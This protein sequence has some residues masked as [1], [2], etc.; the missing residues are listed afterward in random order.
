MG[1]PF[2]PLRLI[3]A[4][5]R[6]WL[7]L[8][9]TAAVLAA[10]GGAVAWFKFQKEYK[11][12]AQLMRQEAAS[13]F[14]AS[15]LGEPFKPRE[16]SVTTLVSLMKSPVVMDR[17]S[18]QTQ[19]SPGQIAGGLAIT[20]ERNTDLITLKFSSRRSAQTVVRVLNAFGA[21][22]VR[23]TRE[24]QS[25]EAGEMNRLLKRQ[26]VKA[27][28]DLRNMNRELLDFSKEANLVSVDK[29]IDAYLRSIGEMELKLETTRIEHDTL[30]LKINALERELAA[31]NP[32]VEHLQVARERLASLL[33]QYT[34]ANPLVEEQKAT[35]KELEGR[36]QEVQA[37]PITP[38]HQGEG[39]LA[40]SFYAELVGLK[41]QKEVTAAQLEKLKG[42]RAGLEDKLR[43]LPEKG[44][45]LARIRARQQSLEAAQSLL[46][47][48][49]REAQLYE[50]NTIG[51]YRFFEAKP[52]EVETTGR[53]TKVIMLTI[54][55]GIAGLLL[56]GLVVC[57][58]ETL[59]DRVKT[60]ADV[61]RVTSL[62]L[63]ASLPN[64]DRLDAVAQSNWAFR[65]CL[66]LQSK[67]ASTK[68]GQICGFIS[69]GSG[70]GCSTWLEMLGRAAA[71][72]HEKVLIVTNAAPVNGKVTP[73]ED[74]LNDPTLITP[75]PG[76]AHWLKMPTDW[77]WESGHR[78]QWR[79]ALELWGARGDLLVLVELTG[80]DQPETM[81]LA[82]SLPQ[83]IW[84]CGNGQAL[85]RTVKERILAFSHAGCPLVGAVLNRQTKLLPWL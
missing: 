79:Q 40:A 36:L 77:R 75:E 8:L 14:R 21:E 85:G 9:V 13:T 66:A 54:A 68:Q 12:G 6:R 28:E 74:V 31:N 4:L 38:P 20:P 51:Y 63:L 1:L 25:Q 72:R 47:S 39:G 24:M 84:L 44:M 17:V 70:E 57:L 80:A 49:Q 71:Q 52:E 41:T 69:S 62:P 76:K 48:R 42:V 3:S 81:L 19:L 7:M 2:D 33:Q 64:L 50:E 82:E 56:S 67:L 43:G 58:G 18:Q 16:L 78:V 32:A 45:Q 83:L 27:E 26:L 5:W 46:A 73:L 37:G 30:D 10:A 22:V 15:E 61:K 35:V 53:T 65:T 29:E 34:D 55:G 60:A 59:D 11:V 23:L